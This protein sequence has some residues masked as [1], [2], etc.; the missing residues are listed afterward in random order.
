MTQTPE[1]KAGIEEK[2]RRIREIKERYYVTTPQA[3]N[4]VKEQDAVLT[5]PSRI[6]DTIN[7]K[8]GKTSYPATPAR[9]VGLY[10]A[11]SG[12]DINHNF[13]NS[14]FKPEYID[15]NVFIPGIYGCKRNTKHAILEYFGIALASLKLVRGSRILGGPCEINTRAYFC[16]GG[17]NNNIP[18]W[19][20]YEDSFV[21]Y[22]KMAKEAQIKT[23][24]GFGMF[25]IN[26]FEK[27]MVKDIMSRNNE[28]QQSIMRENIDVSIIEEKMS[29][30]Q[31]LNWKELLSNANLWEQESNKK[32]Y[33]DSN[34]PYWYDLARIAIQDGIEHRFE[35]RRSI[36]ER[37]L[38]QRTPKFSSFDE[39]I[40]E[41]RAELNLEVELGG[42]KFPNTITP[43]LDVLLVSALDNKRFIE[44][45]LK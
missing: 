9:I 37:Y 32:R 23:D 26:H 28:D 17:I 1:Y 20:H 8:V 5:L 40:A 36:I 38:S 44:N 39:V 10:L 15:Q 27:N 12:E 3:Y 35:I 4:I 24:A 14:K 43:T 18:V 34:L 13:A 6:A 21:K 2:V 33:I 41:I 25:L 16:E 30:L 19:A 29:I 11:L 7:K 45:F 22:F 31:K 42:R